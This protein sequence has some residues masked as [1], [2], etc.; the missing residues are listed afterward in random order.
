LLFVILACP[1]FAC[2]VD[3]RATLPLTRAGGLF[4]I[5]VAINGTTVN[6]VLDSGAER[7]VVALKS[8]DDLAIARDEWVSTDMQGAGGVDR[9]RLGRPRTL[10]LGGIAL[11]RHTVAQ[12]NSVVIG[13]VP[14]MVEGHKVAGLLGQDYLSLFDLD[15]DPAAGTA[16]LYSVTACSGSFPPWPGRKISLPASRPIRNI[17]VLPVRVAGQMLAAELDTGSSNSVIMAPGMARLSLAA[18]GPDKVRGFGTDSVVAREQSFTMQVGTLPPS[19][20]KLVISSFH[21]LRS[22]DMLLGADWLMAR[23]VWIS[24]ATNQVFVPE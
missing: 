18:G 20:T 15:L 21:A 4:L 1:A 9:R 19:E 7:T 22:V 3:L 14:D 13:P 12:D 5:P 6:F 8:A 17:L 11:R 16:K 2:R 10:T 24:W 23:H